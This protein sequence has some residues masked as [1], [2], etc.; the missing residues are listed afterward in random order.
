MT[1]NTRVRFSCGYCPTQADGAIINGLIA[2]PRAWMV[3]SLQSQSGLSLAE[4]VCSKS[5]ARKAL[6]GA[7]IEV[8]GGRNG[9]AV[10]GAHELRG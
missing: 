6:D 4:L 2:P 7:G 9:L 5:C 3:V 1:S 10:P 8:I